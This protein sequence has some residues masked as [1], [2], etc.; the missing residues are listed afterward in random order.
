MFMNIFIFL[1]TFWQA[2]AVQVVVRLWDNI[3]LVEAVLESNI[4]I[5]GLDNAVKKLVIERSAF[6]VNAVESFTY[7]LHE[8]LLSLFLV[9]CDEVR[10]RPF[11]PLRGS[12]EMGN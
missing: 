8:E 1:I 12:P 11:E 2:V 7:T 4:W 9:I 6:C 10:Q 3:P 5:D